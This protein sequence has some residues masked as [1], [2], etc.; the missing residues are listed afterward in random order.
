[1]TA[2]TRTP[3]TSTPVPA[4]APV[5]RTASRAG[6]SSRG[7]SP[8]RTGSRSR[9]PH[10]D[11]PD[12]EAAFRRLAVLPACRERRELR[13]DLTTAWLP[14]AH[15]I[16]T[17]FRNRGESMDDLKQVAA[18]AL[19]K[20]VDRF[21]PAQGNA[22]ESYAVPTITGEL[23]RHFRDHAWAV[24][25]P[26]RVQELRGRVRRARIELEQTQVRE[27]TLSQLAFQAGLSEEEVAEG[28]EAMGSYS[29]L[30][31]DRPADG[32]D[33]GYSLQD[34][35]GRIDGAFDQVVDRE[36]VKP[37]LRALPERDKRILCMRFFD[38]MTQLS[39]AEELGI[40]Q[41]HVSRL[42]TKICAGL[43]DQALKER[44]VA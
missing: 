6:R 2:T 42:L 28:E 20:A 22:F 15:R 31:L 23:K 39:I 16:A 24:H 9:H 37:A 40:S 17:R 35:I 32:A 29:S 10:H 12:T 27:P 7:G 25:V 43:R 38:G 41:M 44:G 19:V 26:R 21:E 30:S 3:R 4:P 1:M 34:R 36:A 14:M 18:V 13:S 33:D 11:A 8:R 5:S